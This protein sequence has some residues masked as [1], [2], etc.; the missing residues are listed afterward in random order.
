MHQRLRTGKK[1]AGSR[2]PWLRR[3]VALLALLAAT[4]TPASPPAALIEAAQAG[5]A[6]AQASLGSR[7]YRGEGMDRDLAGAFTWLR[8]AAEQGSPSAQRGLVV[9]YYNGEG[10]PQNLVEALKWALIASEQGDPEATRHRDY[11][12]GRLAP[13]QVR[14]AEQRAAAW[15]PRAETGTAR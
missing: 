14:E 15:A 7:L 3:L 1:A 2:A 11:L 9:L 4:A 13:F 5:D 12:N 6:E 10:T 8:R